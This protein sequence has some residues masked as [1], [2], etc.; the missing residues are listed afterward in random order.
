MQTTFLTREKQSQFLNSKELIK[1]KIFFLQDYKFNS[2]K[3]G[4]EKDN[5]SMSR[6]KARS[7]TDPPGVTL[8]SLETCGLFE[9]FGNGYIPRDMT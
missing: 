6:E 9:S 7:F 2:G 4:G 3:P 1:N 5:S 8:T